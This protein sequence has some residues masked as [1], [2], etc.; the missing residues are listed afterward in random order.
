VDPIGVADER[1]AEVKATFF[2]RCEEDLWSGQTITCFVDATTI[3]DF[4]DCVAALTPTQRDRLQTA[5]DAPRR[6]GKKQVAKVSIDSTPQ[7]ALVYDGTKLLGTTPLVIKVGP[8]EL[9]IDLAL[10]DYDTKRVT[11]G[12]RTNNVVHVVLKRRRGNPYELSP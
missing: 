2:R 5:L 1:H 3:P 9:E 4:A 6:S 11:I 7:G 12:A 10:A 8:R